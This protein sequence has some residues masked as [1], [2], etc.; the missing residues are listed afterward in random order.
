[1]QPYDFDRYSSGFWLFEGPP[2]IGSGKDPRKN[3]SLLTWFEHRFS[4]TATDIA[5]IMAVSIRTVQRWHSA[6]AL[7]RRDAAMILALI[8]ARRATLGRWRQ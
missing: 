2:D 4:Y 3:F 8:G 7:P 5:Q 6:K 1:M